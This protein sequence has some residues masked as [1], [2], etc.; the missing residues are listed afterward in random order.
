M[1]I[2][3]Q[4]DIQEGTNTLSEEESKHC[5]L[6]LRYKAGDEITL[7]D[8]KGGIY[9][10]VLTQITKK[11][12]EYEIRGSKMTLPKNF[13]IHLAIAPTKNA[14]RMEWMIEKIAELGVD[15]VTL[16][17]TKNSER[18]KMRLDRLEKKAVSAM[19]QSGNPFLLKINPITELEYFVKQSNADIKLIAHV[20]ET[21][22]YFG[23]LL[24]PAKSITILIG[25]EGDFSI[26]EVNQ[27][28]AH[29][30]KAISLGQHVLRT[31][32]A[33]L[34]TCAQINMINR[35]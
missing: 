24:Q 2:F 5:S 19:K 11:A 3:Y 30:F 21:H 7:F 26:E 20:D 23:D 35:Y 10:A 14:D 22:A 9:D 33:G 25:P 34:V 1:A 13:S 31:E 16:L 15:E 27:S 18:K 4:K 8:G 17:Q 29:D 12:C 32:T 28:K 6:V